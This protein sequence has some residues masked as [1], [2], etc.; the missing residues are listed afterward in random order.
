MFLYLFFTL[1]ALLAAAVFITSYLRKHTVLQVI[2]AVVVRESLMA[3]LNVTLEAVL[4]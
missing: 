1:E 4:L 2:K 3:G